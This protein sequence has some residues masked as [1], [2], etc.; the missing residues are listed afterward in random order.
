MLPL[1]PSPFLHLLSCPFRQSRPGTPGSSH[2]L[3]PPSSH[4][5]PLSCSVGGLAKLQEGRGQCH[6]EQSS[7]P[8]SLPQPS[9]QRPPKSCPWSRIPRATELRQTGSGRLERLPSP[10]KQGK[11]HVRGP[12]L[13]KGQRVVDPLPGPSHPPQPG[14]GTGTGTGTAQP[15]CQSRSQALA[16]GPGHCLHREAGARPPKF[17]V[18]PQVRGSG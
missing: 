15:C 12:T 7:R 5:F 17:H 13:S 14:T 2:P 10:P 11:L 4:P 18:S 16:A 1:Q 3:P 6:P 8:T 9:R